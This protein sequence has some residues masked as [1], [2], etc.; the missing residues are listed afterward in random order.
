MQKSIALVAFLILTLGGGSLI[1]SSF[2]PGEWYAALEKPAFNPPGWLFGPV[3]SA[4][5]ILIA[6]AGW[7]T[8][9]RGYRG[10]AMQLWFAQLGVNFI[11]TPVFF[12]AGMLG[13][14]A[15]VIAVLIVLVSLYIRLTWHRD[16]IS[17][18]LMTPYLAWISFAAILNISIWWMN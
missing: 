14:A 7:R 13:F 6:I 18:L 4:L 15:I 5:Y 17:A 2:A 9:N 16:R 11:W 8:W 12:G 10:L 1:G 3:W